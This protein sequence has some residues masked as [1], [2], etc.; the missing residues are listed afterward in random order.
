[1]LTCSGH[2]Y[3]DHFVFPRLEWKFTTCGK[4]GR[5]GPSQRVCDS[6]YN[7]TNLHELVE[8][9]DG[10]QHWVAPVDGKKQN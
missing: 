5:L 4:T 9:I 6:S 7:N 8:V 1:M 2:R 3:Y 10:I